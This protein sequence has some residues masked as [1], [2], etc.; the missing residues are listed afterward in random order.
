MKKLIFFEKNIFNNLFIYN[1]F[2]IYF[3]KFIIEKFKLFLDLLLYFEKYQTN[4]K[5]P[6]A[7]NNIKNNKNNLLTLPQNH[8]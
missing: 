5:F 4:F 1:F 3:D 2:W 6:L 7:K 8:L